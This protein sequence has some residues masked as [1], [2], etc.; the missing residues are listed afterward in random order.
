MDETVF[1]DR[2]EAGRLLAEQYDGPTDDL[3]VLGI[4]RG[5][6]A[7]AYPVAITLGAPL[8]VITARKLPI[9]WSPEMGFGAIAPD[10]TVELNREVV[11]SFGITAEEIDSISKRVLEEVHRRERVYRGGLPPVPLK[12][13][14]VMLV[15]DGLATGYTMIAS[16]GMVRKLGAKYICAA[17]AVSPVDTAENIRRMVDSLLVPRVSRTY[18]FAVASF[19]RDFHD[20]KD[21]EVIDYMERARTER[22]SEG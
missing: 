12:G 6:V 11:R 8:D 9:P 20:M 10:G 18:S 1:S 5:G 7:V 13:M 17:A 16:I 15:D 22:V 4:A 19:Y 2:E 21:S 3:V 14:N